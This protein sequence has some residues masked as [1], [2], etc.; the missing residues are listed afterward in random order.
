MASRLVTDL[1]AARLA[2]GSC[3][4]QVS[5]SVEHLLASELRR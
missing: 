4:W 2:A 3:C 1:V 5:P